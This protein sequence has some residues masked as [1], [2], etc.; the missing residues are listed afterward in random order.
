MQGP[1][2]I[3]QLSRPPDKRVETASQREARSM[4]TFQQG[5]QVGYRR[6]RKPEPVRQNELILNRVVETGK[7]VT[8]KRRD[9]AALKL[10]NRRIRTRTYGGVRG[11]QSTKGCLST[12]SHAPLL[13][14]L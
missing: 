12:R 2:K 9:S 3:R 7:L 8:A 14:Y 1:Q 4:G 6:R 11:R 5:T 13:I 10:P